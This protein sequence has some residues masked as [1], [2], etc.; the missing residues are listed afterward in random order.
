MD[1]SD[2]IML[3]IIILLVALSALTSAVETAI[4]ASS[5]AKLLSM[6][7]DESVKKKSKIKR[8]IDLK[9]NQTRNISSIL[10]GNNI[11][12]LSASAM[13]TFYV[14]KIFG[15]YFIALG[16]GIL[17]LVI[18]IFGEVAPKNVAV[19]IPEN[20]LITLSGPTKIVV[21][22]LYPIAVIVQKLAGLVARLFGID[23]SNDIETY[24]E[25][26]LKTMV[27]LSHAG[28]LI[29]EEEKEMI[30]NVFELDERT[31]RDVM[32]P[33]I[34]MVSVSLDATYEEVNEIFRK[35][36]FTR[37]PVY[38][39]SIDNIV[40]ILNVKDLL[41]LEDNERHNFEIKNIIRKAVYVYEKK[42]VLEILES[43][44]E[45]RANIAI[46]LDE[47]GATAGMVTLEDV[48]EEI[49]GDIN[50]EYDL[51]E[52]EA[53]KKISENEFIIEGSA[54]ITDVYE[55]TG[56]DLATDEVESIGGV[57][58]SKT[59][60]IPKRGQAV[61]LDNCKLQVLEMDG[62]RI[63]KIKLTKF[64]DKTS[65]NDEKTA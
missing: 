10:V 25:E 2:N 53:I 57:I 52:D 54:N 35:E 43:L 18:L 65:E 55:A 37:L 29:E 7:D 56:V 36:Q 11:I 44:K 39:E 24:T 38:E 61:L 19:H 47:Y 40:G 23:V 45:E 26:E 12:N 42:K 46:V 60:D 48:I 9:E 28:G 50:D 8:A 49:V 5:K 62:N 41:L 4:T 34:D 20:V 51:T 32:V 3:P 30:H 63:S 21:T 17:T 14:S 13:M 1:P 27:D 59:D 58:L 31:A 33:R 15:N 6:L 16:T 22:I 64:E